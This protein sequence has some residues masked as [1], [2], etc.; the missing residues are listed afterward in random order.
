MIHINIEKTTEEEA[1][2]RVDTMGKVEI[3]F[4]QKV[5][6]VGGGVSGMQAALDLA[7]AGYPVRLIERRAELGGLA[8]ELYSLTPW[9]VPPSLILDPMMSEVIGHPMITTECS[10]ELQGLRKTGGGFQAVKAAATSGE[11]AEVTI[12]EVVGTPCVVM[13]TGLKPFDPSPIPEFGY[14]KYDDVLTTVQLERELSETE[15]ALIAP[16]GREVSRVVFIQCAGSRVKKRGLSYCSSICCGASIK[17]ALKIKENFPETEVIVLYIDIR[18]P[19]KHG[20]PLYRRAKEAGVRFIRGQPSMIVK[21]DG[22]LEVCGENTL[23]K[24]LYEI[25]ADLA[26]LSVGLQMPD[27]I[28]S[29]LSEVGLSMRED[30]LPEDMRPS[31]RGVPGLFLA[32]CLT[33]PKSVK[34]S[35][36]QGSAAAAKAVRFME[37]RYRA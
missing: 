22:R 29:M 18:T 33:D 24:E 20:E 28:G 11:G 12:E 31:D 27:D 13:A 32:G 16:S 9:D 14:S 6:V 3:E 37:N 34:D 17:N 26:V 15:D 4:G 5:L 2:L 10:V 30:G 21:T 1:P 23:L 36:D 25:E 35:L 19:G 8:R 7:G